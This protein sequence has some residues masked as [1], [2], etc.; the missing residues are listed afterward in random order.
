MDPVTPG[1]DPLR[2]RKVATVLVIA[3]VVVLV[4]GAGVVFV[5]G[6]TSNPAAGDC[7]VTSGGP[8]NAM[9]VRKIDCGAPEATYRVSSGPCPEGDHLTAGDLCL[10]LDVAPGDCLKPV[11]YQGVSAF[12]R[13]PCDQADVRR[14]TR[15]A[16]TADRGGCDGG[17][18]HVYATP[19]RT[20]CLDR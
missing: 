4:L 9:A 16:D 2:R 8:S 3:S 6:R 5:L 14:V 15:V 19:P 1:P 11:E 18:A 7:V 17:P 20:V 13:W 10:A 12:H